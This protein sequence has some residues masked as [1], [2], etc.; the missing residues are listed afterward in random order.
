MARGWTRILPLHT[1]I[2]D[3]YLTQV[4]RLEPPSFFFFVKTESTAADFVIRAIKFTFRGEGQC[5]SA[6]H[7]LEGKNSALK[8]ATPTGQFLTALTMWLPGGAPMRTAA[9]KLHKEFIKVPYLFFSEYPLCGTHNIYLLC[10]YTNARRQSA[11]KTI[12]H[13]HSPLTAPPLLGCNKT[14]AQCLCTTNI[15]FHKTTPKSLFF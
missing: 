2:G 6:R 8:H 15:Q 1:L 14:T 12:P 3:K 11:R 10:D 7:I 9:G 5:K 13:I 4:L